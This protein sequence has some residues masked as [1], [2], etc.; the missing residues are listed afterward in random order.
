VEREGEMGGEGERGE[1]GHKYVPVD[2]RSSVKQLESLHLVTLGGG[3][4]EHT[5]THCN[6]M[7]QHTATR[8]NVL[9]HTAPATHCNTVGAQ[10]GAGDGEDEKENEF[11][12]QLKERERARAREKETTRKS[13]REEEQRREIEKEKEKESDREKERKRDTAREDERVCE[14]ES[15]SIIL[16]A[17]YIQNSANWGGVAL[18]LRQIEAIILEEIPAVAA[19]VRMQTLP[20]T[21]THCNTLQ[22]TATHTATHCNTLRHTSAIRM[23][24]LHHTATHCKHCIT[25]LVFLGV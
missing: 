18:D 1:G 11:V 20:H 23:Q 14:R 22:H 12:I 2:A 3:G 15:T 9:Q 24:T 6:T 4:G 10:G 16:N 17:G 8:C 19:A 21:A 13:E 7:L 5:A 25:P